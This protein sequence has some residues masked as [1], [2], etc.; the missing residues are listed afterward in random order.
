VVLNGW[1]QEFNALYAA[2][3]SYFNLTMHPQT[4][5]RA[6]RI[7]MLEIL[8]KDMRKRRG[9]KFLRCVDLVKEVLS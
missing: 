1:I 3:T 9:V 5:G 2:R 7:A 8:I 4:I 6:S